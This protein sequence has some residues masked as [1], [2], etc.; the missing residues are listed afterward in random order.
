MMRG[1]QG[2][3]SYQERELGSPKNYILEETK[4]T[5]VHDT[6]VDVAELLETKQSRAMGGII[7]SEALYQLA[8]VAENILNN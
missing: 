1:N 6:T 4:K 7:E 2:V 8:S 5:Y 3:C